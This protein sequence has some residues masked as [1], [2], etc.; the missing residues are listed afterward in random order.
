MNQHWRWVIVLLLLPWTLPWQHRSPRGWCA[1]NPRVTRSQA[2]P[3]PGP[4]S[5]LLQVKINKFSVMPVVTAFVGLY[6]IQ[7]SSHFPPFSDANIEMIFFLDFLSSG[8]EGSGRELWLADWGSFAPPWL[9]ILTGGAGG[10]SSHTPLSHI[11]TQVA[12]HKR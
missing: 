11:Y 7:H 3:C 10:L 1:Q 2:C 6:T 8:T 5:S 9:L 4:S 12:L